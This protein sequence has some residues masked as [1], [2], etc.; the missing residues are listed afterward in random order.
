MT[1]F[2]LR[3]VLFPTTLHSMKCFVYILTNKP[4]GTLYIGV[5]KNISERVFA[6]REG[7]G[8]KFTKRYNL[9]HLVYV[10]EFDR[11]DHA[12]DY[13]K[14]LKNWHRSWKTNLIEKDNPGWDDYYPHLHLA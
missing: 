7:R 14:R 6:H 4:H 12:I 11:I 3:F 10:A 1:V 5:T 2:C 13:E 9:H 8:S